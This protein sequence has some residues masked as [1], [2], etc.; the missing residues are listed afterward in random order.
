MEIVALCDVRESRLH[1]MS[2]KYNIANV[3]TDAK[4]LCAR[5]DIEIVSVVTPAAYHLEPV[6]AAAH[7]GRHILIEKP[8]ATTLE[9]ADKIMQAGQRLG[10][11]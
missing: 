1:E 6:R 5:K 4:E 3:Y 7:E 9:A 11:T 10:F 2:S 8:I